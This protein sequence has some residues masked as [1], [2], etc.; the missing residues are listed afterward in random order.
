MKKLITALLSIVLLILIV[1]F[2]GYFYVNKQIKPINTEEEALTVKVEIPYG[3]SSYKI[4]NLLY[5]NNIIRNNKLYYYFIRYPFLFKL[6]YNSTEEE[7][8]QVTKPELKSGTYYLS[9][10]MN[11]I[12]ITQMLS[13]GQ[14]EYI[15][16]SIPEGLTISQIAQILEDNEIC[17]KKE[18]INASKMQKYLLKYN[19]E[20][21]S[22]EGYLFPDTYF[23]NK[24]MKGEAVLTMMADNFY[25]KLS[26]VIN[27]TEYSPK[28]LHDLITLASIVEREYRIP[29]EAPLIASVFKNR[30]RHN[31]GLY[32]CATIVYIITEIQGRPHP[33]R[34]FND[35]LKIDNP[36]NTYMWAGLPPGPISNPGL[37][38]ISAAAN[39]P[40]TNYYF[41][42][43]QDPAEGR[44]LFTTTFDEHK[45]NH[46]L[47][48][49]H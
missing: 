30:L 27:I 9:S 46:N 7:L 48:T 32:S 31:I 8:D 26:T 35:D 37:I 39:P 13:S 25:D 17:S 49:K 11:Y 44:H 18:F 3:T 2:A 47:Y 29:E 21:A 15:K 38:A 5:E 1:V 34:V 45:T 23:L 10:S 14:Q 42:Q 4:S 28:E 36:Y 12:Q 20:E 41:F 33:D 24:G 22:F 19:L 43:I 16:V 40:K 6:F